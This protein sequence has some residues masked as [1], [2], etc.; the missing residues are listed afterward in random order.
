MP[1]NMI[2]EGAK[3]HVPSPSSRPAMIPAAVRA[4]PIAKSVTD[5]LRLGAGTALL[6]IQEK[7]ESATRA[8]PIGT[9]TDG[10][11]GT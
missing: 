4:S 7:I 8:E 10:P 3:I 2:S 1:G 9:M 6:I 5:C 11:S